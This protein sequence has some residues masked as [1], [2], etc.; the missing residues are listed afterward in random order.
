M[1]LTT[2]CFIIG[3]PAQTACKAIETGDLYKKVCCNH[4]YV[5]MD[6]LNASVT[7]QRVILHLLAWFEGALVS[8]IFLDI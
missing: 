3:A 8:I 1:L 4:R 2:I 5:L 7:N 6:F